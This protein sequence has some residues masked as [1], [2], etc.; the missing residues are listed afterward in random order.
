MK[1]PDNNHIYAKDVESTTIVISDRGVPYRVVNKR[2]INGNPEEL[3]LTLQRM[4]GPDMKMYQVI[5]HQ[6]T[7]I[8]IG[9]IYNEY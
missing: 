9:K 2:L 4:N 6:L 7:T 8:T 3:E 5:M 1:F